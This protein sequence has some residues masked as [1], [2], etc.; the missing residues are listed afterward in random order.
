MIAVVMLSAMSASASAAH[1]NGRHRS[2]KVLGTDP[3]GDWGDGSQ[4]QADVGASLGEDLTSAAISMGGERVID[5]EIAVTELPAIGGWPEVSTYSWEFTVDGVP[6]WLVGKFSN[7]SRASCDALYSSSTCPPPRDP[8]TGPFSV[9]DCAMSPFGK[10]CTEVGLVH[11]TFDAATG[12]IVI[13]VPLEM[14]DARP[15]S[16]LAPAPYFFGGAI[17]AFPEQTE[18]YRTF[19]YDELRTRVRFMVPTR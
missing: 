3:A 10:T 14:L 15:G 9:R 16:V 13:P 1:E 7:Y 19:P 2:M 8:G 11:A 6:K 4:Y 17:A 5:F 12:R 18:A